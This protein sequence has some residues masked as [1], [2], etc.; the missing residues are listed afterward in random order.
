MTI[1]IK[2]LDWVQPSVRSTGAMIKKTGGGKDAP[3]VKTGSL[4]T[5]TETRYVVVATSKS[6]RVDLVEAVIATRSPNHTAAVNQFY[7]KKEAEMV[8]RL[9]VAAPHSDFLSAQVV[10]LQFPARGS[11]D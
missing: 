9:A 8:A 10:E 3:P 6:G 4:M 7:N 1:D 5:D 2:Q 11:N